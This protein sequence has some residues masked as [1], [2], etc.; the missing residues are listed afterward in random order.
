[1]RIPRMTTKLLVGSERIFG[2]SGP[3]SNVAWWQQTRAGGM[4]RITY[5]QATTDDVPAMAVLRERSGWAGGAS[6]AGMRLYLAGD[7]HP[8][9]AR[10]PRVAFLAEAEGAGIGYIA[11]HLTT[12]FGCDGELQWIL[13]DPA[14]RGGPAATGLL[15]QLAGWFARHGSPRVCVNVASDNGRARG[16]YRRQGAVELSSHW[17][18]WDDITTLQED[19]PPA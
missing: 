3:L 2:G 18:V 13:V 16:F 19:T 5:R 15:R 10:A 1:M 12:R 4:E 9:H 6:G 17:M 14:H 8:Q 11:G 7:H